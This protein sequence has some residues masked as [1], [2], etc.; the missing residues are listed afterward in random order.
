MGNSLEA[1][2]FN[3]VC[4]AD[5]NATLVRTSTGTWS[6]AYNAQNRPVSFRNDAT[7]TLVE[8]AYDYRG[9]RCTKKVTVAGTVT[10]HEP[11]KSE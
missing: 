5:G 1:V 10:L 11:L 6:I 4:N 2:V 8:C 7:D 9:R 3:A